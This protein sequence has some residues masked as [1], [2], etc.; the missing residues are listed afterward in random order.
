[1]FQSY[2]LGFTMYY[3]LQH[4]EPDYRLSNKQLSVKK[5]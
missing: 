5:M 4:Y 3:K 1:M 2:N